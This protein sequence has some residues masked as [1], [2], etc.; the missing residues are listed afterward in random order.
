MRGEPAVGVQA[1][2]LG[3]DVQLGEAVADARVVEHP[4]LAGQRRPASAQG[5]VDVD[6]QR[7]G[8]ARRARA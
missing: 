1:Q 3:L 5:D 6:L 2:H 8:E 7:E 4:A